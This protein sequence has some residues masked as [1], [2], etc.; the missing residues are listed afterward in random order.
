MIILNKR[1]M[2]ADLLNVMRCDFIFGTNVL[3]V[4][5]AFI[6]MTELFYTLF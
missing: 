3:D 5:S 6:F 2:I 4:I 1:I